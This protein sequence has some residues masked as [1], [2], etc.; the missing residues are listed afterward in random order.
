[1]FLIAT[2]CR[3]F[4]ELRVESGKERECAVPAT[5]KNRLSRGKR[6]LLT[7][8]ELSQVYICLIRL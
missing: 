1:M 8:Q 4:A 3:L 2:V 7:V 6:F 5:N